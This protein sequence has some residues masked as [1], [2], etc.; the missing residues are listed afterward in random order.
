DLAYEAAL[1][2]CSEIG[3]KALDLP[4]AVAHRLLAA[5]PADLARHFGFPRQIRLATRF[6]FLQ[7]PLRFR[8]QRLASGRCAAADGFGHSQ[9]LLA[10]IETERFSTHHITKPAEGIDPFRCRRNR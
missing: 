1:R 5:T 2:R 3:G 4:V 7:S 8:R 10:T 9:T 6:G